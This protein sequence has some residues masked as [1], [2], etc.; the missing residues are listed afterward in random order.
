M[1]L[2]YDIFQKF[3]DD[4][5]VWIEAVPTLE[6][7]QERLR[8]LANGGSSEYRVYDASAGKFIDSFATPE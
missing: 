5:H 8:N 1:D 3:S 6:D 4:E 2:K 7:A